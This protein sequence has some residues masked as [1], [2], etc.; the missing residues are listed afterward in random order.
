MVN[1]VGGGGEIELERIVCR[2]AR[3]PA[4]EAAHSRGHFLAPLR[5]AISPWSCGE[6][7]FAAGVLFR[8]D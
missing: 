2:V 6:A 1:D 4:A 8:I 3:T 5:T 7:L